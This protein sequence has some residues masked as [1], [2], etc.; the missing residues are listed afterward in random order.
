MITLG[1]SSWCVLG[2]VALTLGQRPW[3]NLMT[4]GRL[5]S[6]RGSRLAKKGL[7]NVWCTESVKST[8]LR[9]LVM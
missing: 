7:Q 2:R 5:D 1:T 9:S 6:E 8:V 3:K 4:L